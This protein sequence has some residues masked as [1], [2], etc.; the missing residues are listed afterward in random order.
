LSR[1]SLIALWL[2]VFAL[3]VTAQAGGDET[4]R[5]ALSLFHF[6]L[7]YVAGGLEDFR[8]DFELSEA[9]EG[10]DATEQGVED[11]II[12]ESLLPLLELYAAHPEWGADVEMQGLMAD[13]IRERHPNVLALMQELDS[14]LAWNS[15]HY[16]DELWTAQPAEVMRR[17]RAAAEAAFAD[18]A[19]TLSPT[20]F[21]QEGQFGMGMGE[22]L[23]ENGIA[24]LPRNLFGLHYP[25][26]A[27][28][29]LF[30]GEGMDVIIGG[31]SWSAAVGGIHFD[32]R[33]TFLDDGELLATDEMNP[34]LYP[35]F[36]HDP[37]AVAAYE[38]ELEALVAEGYEIV[39]VERLV[40]EL[41]SAGYM[42]PDLPPL[43]DGSWQPGDT[44]N[45]GLWMGDGGAFVVD[46]RDG[47][48]RR[49][50]HRAYRDVSLAQR[51][52]DAGL[53]EDPGVLEEGWKALF[54]AGVSDATG[55][56]PYRSEVAYSLYH[57]ARAGELADEVFALG[58]VQD[59]SSPGWWLDSDGE[60]L[61][62][63]TELGSSP[64]EEP[65]L[66][67]SSGMETAGGT[68]WVD[69]IASSRAP[70]AMGL[71]VS[72][73]GIPAD[74]LS[75]RWLDIPWDRTE[76]RFVPAG[77]DE[78]LVSVPLALFEEQEKPVGVPLANGILEVADDLFIVLDPITMLL[79]ARV[80]PGQE[81]V[82][83]VDE[84]PSSDGREDWELWFVVGEDAALELSRRLVGV[85]AGPF[86]GPRENSP[87]ALGFDGCGCEASGRSSLDERGLG[88]LLVLLFLGAKRRQH[89]G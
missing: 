71:R 86:E 11:A 34:Y 66:E 80:H 64:L 85:P 46:E 32:V 23:P 45:L 75:A 29:P 31:H 41:R 51:L 38:A 8:D 72:F 84:T 33:W 83:F 60:L 5:Y 42:P 13:V 2:A 22:V 25:E 37:G 17:S 78:G 27:R 44:N 3:P 65:L 59:P 81:F 61:A 76:L 47:D 87:E 14:Q 39:T 20:V 49:R 1:Y 40:A 56:N 30:A 89:S 82:R 35:N 57:S 12:L 21:S 73:D 15:F 70:G 55:W 28:E 9:W 53:A 36:V 68:S 69:W 74:A 48:V 62:R 67:V 6:N 19:L 24:V 4:R 43:I 50:W 54:L 7:Q 10:L 18:A 88:L 52:V 58:P 77:R 63:T 26:E 79:C 16:S